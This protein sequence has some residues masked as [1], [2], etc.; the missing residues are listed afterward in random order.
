MSEPTHEKI[1]A[2]DSTRSAL[3]KLAIIL[4]MVF[5]DNQDIFLKKPENVDVA[6]LKNLSESL[7]SVSNLFQEVIE[8]WFGSGLE[9]FDPVKRSEEFLDILEVE[10]GEADKL[11]FE[12]I[13]TITIEINKIDEA[14]ESLEKISFYLKY[15]EDLCRQKGLSSYVNLSEIFRVYGVEEFIKILKNE[16]KRY[17]IQ[18]ERNNLYNNLFNISKLNT[19]TLKIAYAALGISGVFA[20]VAVLDLLLRLMGR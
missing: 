9:G 14:L 17:N 11:D 15:Y 5:E 1:K 12:Q 13:R 2:E 10:I 4:K 19:K 18:I 6:S 3:N 8:E 20:V 16:A 7:I